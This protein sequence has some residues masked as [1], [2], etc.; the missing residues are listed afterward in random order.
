MELLIWEGPK[1]RIKKF[2]DYKSSTKKIKLLQKFYSQRSNPMPNYNLI[3]MNSFFRT[4]INRRR[5]NLVNSKT[6]WNTKVKGLSAGSKHKRST[7]H[8]KASEKIGEKTPAKIFTRS[9]YAN[10]NKSQN[11]SF[12]SWNGEPFIRKVSNSMI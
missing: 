5:E 2:Y 3:Q 8:A 4:I 9:F 10:M 11:A 1:E 7:S 12:E 6:H